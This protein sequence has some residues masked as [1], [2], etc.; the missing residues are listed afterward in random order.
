MGCLNSKSAE[1]KKSY[2]TELGY[3]FISKFLSKLS[4][5]TEVIVIRLKSIDLKIT[6][7]HA[8]SISPYVEMKL[9]P[10]SLPGDQYQRSSYKPETFTPAWAPAERF[11]FIVTDKQLASITISA[12]NFSRFQKKH[13]P[14]G[15]VILKLK[16]FN[17]FSTT[18]K[19]IK[20]IDPETGKGESTIY[21]D[22]ECMSVSAACSVQEQNVYE[23]E[24]WRV[25][26]LWGSTKSHY[27]PTDPGKYSTA[28]GLKFGHT[29]DDVLPALTADW[30]ITKHLFVIATDDDPDGWQYAGDIW[31]L[32]WYPRE[33]DGLCVRRRT[34]RRIISAPLDRRSYSIKKE[35]LDL[36]I[37][38][39]T[40]LEDDESNGDEVVTS[41]LTT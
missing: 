26:K 36:N 4:P 21:I 23:Y 19:E 41:P 5:E 37:D 27:L 34:W 10:E 16:Q 13:D 8:G 20:L 2:R 1:T 30:S 29:F 31:S 25:G 15:D 40:A 9:S 14:L 38:A 12:F 11:Q 22:V 7:G 3:A 24:R 33:G 18:Q 28:D 6:H 17:P 35:K 39:L 32:N